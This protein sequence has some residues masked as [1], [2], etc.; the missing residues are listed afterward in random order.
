MSRD[1]VHVYDGGSTSSPLLGSYSGNSLPV[2]VNSSSTQ[3]LVTFTSDS[4]NESS[5]FV[6]TY[7]GMEDITDV[8]IVQGLFVSCEKR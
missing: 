5:G 3:L 8:A 7:Q 2:A 6:A 4:S 1:V